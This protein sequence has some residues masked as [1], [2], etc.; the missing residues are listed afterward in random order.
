MLMFVNDS[1]FA[2]KIAE[3]II[4]AHADRIRSI[5]VSKKIRGQV[6]ASLRIIRQCSRRYAA[7]R[8]LVDVITRLNSA[9]GCGS[10]RNIAGRLRIPVIRLT[11]VNRDPEMAPLLPADLGLAIN[12][13]QILKESFLSRFRHG[14]LNLHASRLPKDRGV[15]PALW[16]FARGDPWIWATIYQIDSGLD[17]G[18]IVEQF[19]LKV[20]PN[21]TAFSLYERV[22]S[23]GGNRLSQIVD[24]LYKGELV[25]PVPQERAERCDPFSWPNAAFDLMLAQSKRRLI[26]SSDVVRSFCW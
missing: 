1:H 9:R 16:A 17:T 4:Y 26:S 6:R 3:P 15:S 7:Y 20:Q 21:D 23:E 12:F 25:P 11:D 14:V 18:P 5:V 13:D 2:S 22:C 24:A 8:I 19:Q 10:V